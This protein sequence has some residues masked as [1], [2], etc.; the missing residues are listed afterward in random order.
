MYKLEQEYLQVLYTHGDLFLLDRE[1]SQY[2]NV[3]DILNINFIDTKNK[4]Y[5]ID[6]ID[7]NF[8]QCTLY[9]YCIIL[10]KYKYIQ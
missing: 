1:L 5:Q 4:N 6:S 3:F 9:E 2:T 8:M 7:N 10:H